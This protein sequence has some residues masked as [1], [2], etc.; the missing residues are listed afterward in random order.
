MGVGSCSLVEAAPDFAPQLEAE[1]RKVLVES[2]DTEIAS[3]LRRVIWS[4]QRRSGWWW[5]VCLGSQAI[6]LPSPPVVLLAAPR[7]GERVHCTRVAE[8]IH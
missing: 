4:A 7:W 1:R 3:N 2:G 5:R 6:P 8:A